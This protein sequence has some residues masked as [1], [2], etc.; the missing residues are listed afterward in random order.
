MASKRGGKMW[1]GGRIYLP[2][3]RERTKTFA[4][5][6]E[7]TRWEKAERDQP[8]VT[9]ETLAE[10][11]TRTQ[12]QVLATLSPSTA[13]TYRSHLRQRVLPSLGH[14]RM[15][16]IHTG[17]V[18]A[19]A[20]E[21][22]STGVS[23][24]SVSGSLN[25]L[26]RFYRHAIKWRQMDANPVRAA[27]RPRPDPERA[28]PT[29]TAAEVDL[30]ADRCAA[31]KVYYGDY[32]RLAASLGLR[33]GELL[34]LRVLDVDLEQQVLTVRQAWSAGT[35]GPP[36][37]GR[38]RQ[39]VIVGE[40]WEILSRRVPGRPRQALVLTGEL[41]GR[42]YHTN[43]LDAV[44]WPK[45]MTE[46][47][48]EGTHFHDLRATAIVNW[49]RSGLPLSTVRDMAGHSSLSTTNLYARLARSDLADALAHLTAY[50]N[51]SRRE[52]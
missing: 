40:A 45:L 3:G 35:L 9:V 37:W 22:S 36:K 21:W 41:G 4:T 39:V 51:R 6:R 33:A 34:A 24:S 19:A 42:L 27:E 1:R 52:G 49:I 17:H 50:E 47:G 48:L 2:N 15:T 31:V 38:S 30:V 20:A 43:F 25:C 44:R 16:Q 28:I 23:S 11:V 13:A 5:K 46:L 18:E 8:A 26:S 32:V 10:F 29:L 12:G 14:R 7:A